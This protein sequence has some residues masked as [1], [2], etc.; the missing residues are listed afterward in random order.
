MSASIATAGD[1]ANLPGAEGSLGA[2]GTQVYATAWPV[3]READRTLYRCRVWDGVRASAPFL[4][5]AAHGFLAADPVV[6][7]AT[8]AGADE[9]AQ[10]ILR[11]AGMRGVPVEFNQEAQDSAVV[12]RA[13][14]QLATPAAGNSVQ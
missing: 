5:R 13:L 6:V 8:L 7:L 10:G 9:E 11:R 12:A 4:L 2:A 1:G 14:A 3:R